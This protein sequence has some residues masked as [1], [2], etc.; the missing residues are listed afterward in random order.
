MRNHPS[1]ET[2]KSFSEMIKK[3]IGI[4]NQLRKD[5]NFDQMN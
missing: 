4:I 3:K 2:G 5:F 1:S